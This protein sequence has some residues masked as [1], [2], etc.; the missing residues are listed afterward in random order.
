MKKI[1]LI[2]SGMAIAAVAILSSCG[3][4][5]AVQKSENADESAETTIADPGY[6]RS[7]VYELKA[8]ELLDFN[9][10]DHPVVVDFSATWCGPC[11]NFKPTFEKM[12]EKYNGKVEFI[13]VDVD[14]CPE[15]AN[16]FEVSAI[17]FV[18]F[19]SSDGT[20]NSNVGLMDEA[21]LEE[22]I[23]NLINAQK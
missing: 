7:G 8:D 20:I 4:N 16:K 2:L 9:G 11:K 15:V 21:A 22:A 23:T 5:S 6:V 17:P 19:V 18:L 14:R 3:N 13:A 12:A 1:S 10:I